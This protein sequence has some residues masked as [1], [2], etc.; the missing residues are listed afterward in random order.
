MTRYDRPRAGLWA[1][2][3]PICAGS[4]VACVAV[5]LA[6]DPDRLR[7]GRPAP[8]TRPQSAP[9]GAPLGV[10]QNPC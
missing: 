2:L 1:V 6:T 8:A 10:L 9:L 4:P 7:R 3:L 5:T